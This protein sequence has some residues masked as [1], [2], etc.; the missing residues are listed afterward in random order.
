MAKHKIDIEKFEKLAEK[1][2]A[3]GHPMRIGIIG[4]LDENP[5]NVTKIYENLQVSQA[6]ASH[7]LNILRNI[8][9]LARRAEGKNTIYSLKKNALMN[10]IDS[11][12]CC[13][14]IE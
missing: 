14:R 13:Q 8:G 4:L 2:R 12:D 9:L 10:I 1:F 3:I 5:M 6:T 11:A 7:H